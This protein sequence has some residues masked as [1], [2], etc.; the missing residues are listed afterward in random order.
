MRPTPAGR[1]GT[2]RCCSPYNAILERLD[3]MD[4]RIQQAV[5]DANA[6]MSAAV[7]QAG[8]A[9]QSAS[10]ALTQAGIAA[11]KA[12]DAA[13]DAADAAQDAAD[14]AQ[15]LSD[16]NDT[17]STILNSTLGDKVDKLTTA[18]LHLY[19][20]TGSTQSEE[21]PIDGT[22]SNTIP[23][24]DGN[25][26][27]HAADPASGATDKTL[28][29]ANWMSQTGDSSPNNLVHRTGNERKTGVLTTSTPYLFKSGFVPSASTN[30]RTNYHRVLSFTRASV[31][32][33]KFEITII[34]G[35][36]NTRTGFAKVLLSFGSNVGD[37]QIAPIVAIASSNS[38]SVNIKVIRTSNTV[39][40]WIREAQYVQYCAYCTIRYG[41]YSDINS[42]ITGL[43]VGDM[44]TSS[45]P[46]SEP[47]TVATISVSTFNN[48]PLE[49]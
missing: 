30:T 18:G 44:T 3:T 19:S 27:M 12:S 4:A 48:Y 20:H 21:E 22:T 5:D 32:N 2:A 6:A 33:T 49:V 13:A 7:I 8:N 38:W 39:D 41:Q 1:G 16:I 17:I 25:G 36:N 45:D 40:I 15:A 31:N 10:D 11:G 23:I 37:V 28:V 43:S 34:G 46:S 14:A 9:A 29:T 42:T 26:R 24:R 35:L 47:D